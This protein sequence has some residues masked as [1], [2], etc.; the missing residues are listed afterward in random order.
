MHFYKNIGN[1]YIYQYRCC[2]YYIVAIGVVKMQFKRIRDLREDRDY[3]QVQLAEYL[4]VKQSTYSDYESGKINIPIEA[5]LRLA[6]FYEVSI[7][8]IVGVTDS[9]EPYKRK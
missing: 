9:K 6:E 4:H 5:L 8:Y 1:I 7:D 3:T 2:R